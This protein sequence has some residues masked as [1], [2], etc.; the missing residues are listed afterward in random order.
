MRLARIFALLLVPVLAAAT[1][2]AH[3]KK[4]DPSSGKSDGDK[5]FE[6]VVKDLERIEGL[7][8][9]YFDA[10]ENKYLM[11]IR[12]EQ[13]GT[14]YLCSTMRE[15]GDGLYYDS[16]S[17]GRNFPFVLEKTGKTIRMLHRNVY[18]R[19]DAGTPIE[20]AV[21]SGL[22]SS[23]FGSAELESA[24]NEEGGGFLIDPGKLFLKDHW[25][26]G[27]NLGERK[28]D[29]SMDKDGSYFGEVK[30]FPRNSEIETVIHFTSSKPRATEMRIPDSRSM[31]HRYRFSLVEIPESDYVPRLADDRVG[32]FTTQ[33][34]DYTDLERDTPYTWYI[35]RWNLKKQDP[36]AAV[37]PPVEPI[38]Y[39]LANTI[40]VQ[41][42][43]AVRQGAQLWNA[44]FEKAGF[45]D[46]V[47]V[48]QMP[49]DADWDPADVRYNTIQWIV[50]PGG[51][52]A[53]GPSHANP[54]TGELYAADIRVSADFVRG[55]FNSYEQ[56]IDPLTAFAEVT[57]GLNARPDPEGCCAY[58]TGLVSEAGF[59]MDWMTAQGVDPGS[60]EMAK[61]IHDGIVDLIA[62]EVG[63]TLGFRHN[64]RA[65]TIHDLRQVHDVELTRREGVSGSVMDYNPVNL[66]PQGE[67]Q[68]S[69]WCTSLGAYDYWVV[70]YAYTPT[71]AATPEEE[72]PIL[73]EIAS[74]STNPLLTY[75]TDE[76]S[77][78]F[79]AQG[80]D[81]VVNMWDMGPDP[82]AYYDQRLDMSDRIVG[83]IE[84]RFET[85]GAKYPRMRNVYTRAMRQHFYAAATVAKQV[86]GIYHRRDHVQPGGSTPFEPVPAATQRAALDF[87]DRRIFA[88]D[89][90]KMTPGL[91]NKLAPE[92]LDDFDD[93]GYYAPRV[94]FPIHDLVLAA[95]GAVLNRL[96]HPITLNRLLDMPFHV[97]AGEDVVTMDEVF[98]SLRRSIW[99][100][101]A[102]GGN[103]SSTRRNL[104][105]A[106]LDELIALAVRPY[107][108]PV[109]TPRSGD[110]PAGR[111]SPPEDARSFARADLV[112]IRKSIKTAAGGAGLDGATRAHLDETAA[113]IDAALAAGIDRKM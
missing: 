86:G 5:K 4:A 54:F 28:L 108:A 59:G 83:E 32:H 2:D 101:V 99:S 95:Q 46:A 104:Q 41:Y 73:G 51:G 48:K 3:P 93:S 10:K 53:V 80:I 49:D 31:F 29:Y 97:P 107:G 7:F 110:E 82:V 12:P 44:A 42:R 76:D 63:H 55:F 35:N 98:R 96:Y 57:E 92:R 40:P 91:A 1:A 100:E 64:F 74:K 71:G 60:P 88:E 62:H 33:F 106:H 84:Q 26:V 50:Q 13:L 113:R 66:A 39:W 45:R 69:F 43:D 18:Y 112:A 25:A 24:P 52:Y 11:E 109:Y 70:E 6:D 111:I 58:S 68:G 34:Q 14:T 16:G 89:A 36:E 8:T 90:L 23:V 65:S 17:M 61:Y 9:F 21:E 20:S 85:D 19:A 102:A 105:R 37:S 94:D 72:L 103:V 87:L 56:Y 75:A 38:V 27:A 67:T 47:V 22:T 81:P 30:S 77:F 79:G 15:A 78:G